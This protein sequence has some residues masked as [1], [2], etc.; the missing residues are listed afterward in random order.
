[1]QT[2]P[3]IKGEQNTLN[4]LLNVF[5]TSFPVVYMRSENLT[6]IQATSGLTLQ[7]TLNSLLQTPV[8]DLLIN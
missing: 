7:T 5:N 3:A 8:I 4:E 1:M 2:E 6:C